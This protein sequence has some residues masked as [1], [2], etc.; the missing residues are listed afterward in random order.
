MVRA[1]GVC[2]YWF[3]QSGLLLETRRTNHHTVEYT[4]LICC[5]SHSGIC[6][7]ALIVRVAVCLLAVLL[8]AV[9]AQD[10]K[11]FV[12]S[13]PLN[14]DDDFAFQGEYAGLIL[15]DRNGPSCV[16]RQVG[17]QVVA[18]GNG[19][20]DAV[21]FDF[22]L[23]GAGW[24]RGER[25]KMSG[26][27]EGSVLELKGEQLSARIENNL[28]LLKSAAGNNLGSFPR[29]IRKSP[30]LGQAAPANAIVL[31]D[32]TSTDEFY[33]GRMTDDGLLM[34]GAD[35]KRTF[36]DFTL[37]VE[38]RLPYMPTQRGQKRGNSGVYLQSRYEIQ[39]LDS[40]GL[41]GE[42]NECGALYRYQPP[43]INMCF[44]P[45]QWQTYDITLKSPKFDSEGQKVE[46]ARLTVRHNGVTVHNNFNVERKTGAGQQESADPYPIR[47]QNHSDPVRFRNIWIVDHCPSVPK[48]TVDVV[49][50]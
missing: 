14:V 41:E 30:T 6:A 13:D 47:L 4:F 35:V 1:S 36:S 50:R 34:E 5:L 17:I 10:S 38:F 11:P 15:P 29:I 24:N 18:L 44:P 39:V 31:F 22:G 49:K 23:P 46:N 28:L 48:R 42:F 16:Y 20:F 3:A 45:L 26:T 25:I 9:S 33:N 7:M 32:G 40:F 43:A 19:K 21:E 37:H 8:S 12:S 27:R 2:S